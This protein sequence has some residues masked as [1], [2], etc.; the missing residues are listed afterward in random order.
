MWAPIAKITSFLQSGFYSIPPISIT[1]FRQ[2]DVNRQTVPS[3]CQI[4]APNLQTW[5]L[6]LKI[7]FLLQIGFKPKEFNQHL[8]IAPM[9]S[10]IRKYSRLSELTA[11]Q[12]AS[13]EEGSPFYRVIINHNY[14]DLHNHHLL[15]KVRPGWGEELWHQAVGFFQAVIQ[16]C[17]DGCRINEHYCKDQAKQS[18]TLPNMMHSISPFG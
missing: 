3:I 18:R 16:Y 9:P 2:T 12:S 5:K 11:L 1:G 14:H 7:Y 6:S 8:S 15:D 13:S 10:F 17:D 4:Y